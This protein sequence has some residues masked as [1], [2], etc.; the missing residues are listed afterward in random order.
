MSSLLFALGCSQDLSQNK[1]ID[2]FNIDTAE[3]TKETD[4]IEGSDTK[5]TED[6]EDTKDI[7]DTE[8]REDTTDT[9][10]ADL[11]HLSH[12]HQWIRSH[13]WFLYQVHP[14]HN[15]WSAFFSEGGDWSAS[16]TQRFNEAAELNQ[17][18][19]DYGRRR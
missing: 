3:D 9:D 10:E 16:K 6:T 4:D 2:D 15:L 5:Y 8:G 11:S 12:E 19:A 1:Q 7:E 14:M 13:T 17:Q 18:L